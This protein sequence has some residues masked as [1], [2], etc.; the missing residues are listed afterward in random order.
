MNHP[1]TVVTQLCIRCELPYET[2]TG[3]QR[4]YCTY[5][6]RQAAYRERHPKIPV[7]TERQIL[8]ALGLV[9]HTDIASAVIKELRNT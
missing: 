9:L 8:S 5:A 1:A 4:R 3:S 2:T 6:C 7:Y